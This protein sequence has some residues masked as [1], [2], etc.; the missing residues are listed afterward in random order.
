MEPVQGEAGVIVPEEGYLKTARSICTRNN[1]SSD[2]SNEACTS[3]A[4][5]GGDG[6]YFYPHIM[7]RSVTGSSCMC[8]TT[9]ARDIVNNMIWTL[10]YF[11]FG[12]SLLYITRD[13]DTFSGALSIHTCRLWVGNEECV[14]TWNGHCVLYCP[15]VLLIADEVQTGLGRTGM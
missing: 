15:Q 11:T 2:L 8:P 5:R 1:V 12:P 4:R 10:S 7:A 14:V 9:V 3:C 6:T 13:L